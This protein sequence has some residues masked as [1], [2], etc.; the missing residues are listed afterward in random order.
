[1][2]P[3]TR[4]GPYEIGPVRAVP[5]LGELYDAWDHDRQRDVTFRV[6]RVDFAGS[7]DRLTRFEY[8]SHTAAQLVHPNILTVHDIGTDA[9]AAYVVSE[10]IA[11]RTLGE[12]LEAGPLPSAIMAR[13]AAD[14]ASGLAAAHSTGVV[15]R[16]LTPASILVTADGGAK[17]VGLGL[18]AAT[19]NASTLAGGALLGTLRYM[20]PE[21]L[22]GGT[23]D[24]RSDMFTFGTIL[25]EMLTGTRAF[26]GGTLV[27][28]SAV[29]E[30]EGLPPF[31]AGLPAA[32]TGTVGRCLKKDPASRIS[33]DDVVKALQRS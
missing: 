26:G 13:C 3:G 9:E 31:A 29:Q 8:E 19:Q 4:I 21:Q 16:D 32:L 25:Y 22:Q 28:V 1:M 14:L 12:L 10:P 15:H 7:P 27:T 18:A 23:V 5:G 24:E 20:S 11:E 17:V 33:A 6:L 2:T 30:P